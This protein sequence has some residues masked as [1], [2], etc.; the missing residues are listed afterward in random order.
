MKKLFTILAVAAACVACQKNET[1]ALDKGEAISFGN[2]FVEN[3]VRA[4]VDP[5]YSANDIASFKVYGTVDGDGA[6]AVAPV[7]IYPGATVTK[8][9]ADY[10]A[11]WSCT[12]AEGN[13]IKQY[14]V[15]GATYK[16][17]G[18]VDGDKENVSETTLVNG[19]PTTISYT[20]DGV[21]DLLCQTIDQTAKTDGTANGLVAFN[22]NHLLAKAKFTV[23]ND[24]TEATNYLH[25]VRD[26][27]ISNAYNTATYDVAGAQW[28]SAKS[29]TGQAFDAIIASAGSTECAN[30]KLLI[31]GLASVTV[32]FVVDLYY[33]NNGT[34]TLVGT[35]EYT[36]S[37]AK[38]ADINIE[39][40]KA[41]NFQINVK[42][43]ELIQFTVEKKPEWSAT[44]T[45]S[46]N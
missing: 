43:G 21:T 9:T 23:V 11:A 36:D 8:G 31:P 38:T 18:I 12:D 28:M 5:S 26:I 10:G 44:T 45:V 25:K 40:G 34:E 33:V 4:A 19:M 42:V 29:T 15:P 35:T 30:E 3:S 22:F 32:E 37:N 39:A 16:F 13:E 27:K 14:W 41:Y 6:G 7:L 2:A 46:A 1:I 24:S 17:V 20:A